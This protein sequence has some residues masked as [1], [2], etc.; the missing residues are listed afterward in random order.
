MQWPHHGL[1]I[2]PDSPMLCRHHRS[3][4][5]AWLSMTAEDISADVQRLGRLA[6]FGK[7]ARRGGLPDTEAGTVINLTQIR[8]L[9][10][11]RGVSRSGMYLTGMKSSGCS[12]SVIGALPYRPPPSWMPR[13][14]FGF[15]VPSSVE[16]GIHACI[17]RP[18]VWRDLFMSPMISV[19]VGLMSGVRPDITILDRPGRHALM[20]DVG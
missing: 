4:D 14:D 17:S 1:S 10:H 19:D 8:A 3:L 9:R 18:R 6:D 5:R 12:S 7:P 16:P 20:S 15:I 11:S 13:I 2:R